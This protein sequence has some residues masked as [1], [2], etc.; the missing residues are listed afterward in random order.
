[1]LFSLSSGELIEA[2]RFMEDQQLLSFVSSQS[3]D[4]V[5]AEAQ[6][7]LSC[8]SKYV[9]AYKRRL[10]K[11]QS[12]SLQVPVQVLIKPSDIIEIIRLKYLPMRCPNTHTLK[13]G[14]YQQ[15]GVV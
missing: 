8:R 5:A 1:M 6:Y 12:A 14:C 11:L 9:M 7:H 2:A 15:C 3:H 10:K 4:L 13:P